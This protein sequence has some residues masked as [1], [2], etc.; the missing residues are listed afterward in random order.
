[1]QLPS[2]HENSSAD[3]ILPRVHISEGGN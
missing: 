3:A 2:F 1:V